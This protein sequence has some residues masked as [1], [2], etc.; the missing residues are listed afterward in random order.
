MSVS[1][2]GESETPKAS[3]LGTELISAPSLEN[4]GTSGSNVVSEALESDGDVRTGD[5]EEEDCSVSEGIDD[6]DTYYSFNDDDVDAGFGY[7]RDGYSNLGGSGDGRLFNNNDDP[8][9][10]AYECL[11][12]ENVEQLFAKKYQLFVLH[13]RYLHP[14][15]KCTFT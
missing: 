13:A 12:I 15:Q 4:V 6:Y 9:Y 11:T 10:F 2:S 8:E 3:D 5:D 7:S 1:D 14:K